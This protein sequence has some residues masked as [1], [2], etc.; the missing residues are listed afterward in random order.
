MG[1]DC[2]TTRYPVVQAPLALPLVKPRQ[3]WGIDV[4]VIL[5]Y[6]AFLAVAGGLFCWSLCITHILRAAAQSWA[7]GPWAGGF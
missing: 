1:L 5:S 7:I 6:A 4:D 2:W 3:V